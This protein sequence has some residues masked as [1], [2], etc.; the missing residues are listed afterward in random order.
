MFSIMSDRPIC[1]IHCKPVEYL[2]ISQN[3]PLCHICIEEM[4]V[5]ASQTNNNVV[6]LEKGLAII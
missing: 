3:K 1:T 2:C 6:E 5:V 4:K